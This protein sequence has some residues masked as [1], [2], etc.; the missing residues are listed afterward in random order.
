ME[1][2]RKNILEMA[3]HGVKRCNLW[4]LGELAVYTWS[5]FNLITFKGILRSFSALAFFTS[6]KTLLLLQL[7]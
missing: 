2:Q 7:E 1:K 4:D 6:F 3:N 5:D